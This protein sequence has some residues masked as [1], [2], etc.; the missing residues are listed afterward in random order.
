MEYSWPGNI[1][2]LENVMRRLVVLADSASVRAELLRRLGVMAGEPVRTPRVPVSE[3]AEEFGLKEV[4]I[5]AEGA[6][7]QDALNQV[8]WNRSQAAR[9]LQ[10]S[11]KTLLTKIAA[12]R[13]DDSTRHR[14][15]GGEP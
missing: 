1:R 7:I 4:A 9:I 6:A 15:V 5:A 14:T 12:Y 10:V 11:Y 2:E 13:L 8:R 3:S